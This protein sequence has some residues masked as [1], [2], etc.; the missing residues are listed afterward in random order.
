MSCIFLIRDQRFSC[1][2]PGYC[3]F[4]VSKAFVVNEFFDVVARG[5]AVGEK[6]FFMLADALFK[7]RGYADVE[8]FGVAGEDVD[9]IDVRGFAHG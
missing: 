7:F 9:V 1:F 6:F 4:D 3:C 2:F 5:E 8:A